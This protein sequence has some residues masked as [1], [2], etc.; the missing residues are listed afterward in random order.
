[1]P[2][3]GLNFDGLPLG[4]QVV[5]GPYQDNIC[6]TVAEELERAFGGWQNFE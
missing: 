1:M 5:A 6:L 2:F 4:V 3:L